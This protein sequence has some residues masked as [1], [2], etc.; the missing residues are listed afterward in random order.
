MEWYRRCAQSSIA[1]RSD[2]LRCLGAAFQ[3]FR[4][5]ALHT[6]KSE[7]PASNNVWRHDTV[8]YNKGNLQARAHGKRAKK[9]KDK[10]K[11]LDLVSLGH[12]FTGFASVYIIEVIGELL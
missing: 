5:V 10:K 2:P 12:V 1:S 4:S 3:R 11:T 7:G 6:A 9:K 8:F